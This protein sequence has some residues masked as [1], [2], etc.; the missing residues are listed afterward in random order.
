MY[1]H[2]GNGETVNSAEIVIIL[3]LDAAMTG[4]E[5]TELLKRLEKEKKIFDKTVDG[6]PKSLLL[7]VNK[8]GEKAYL[9]SLAASTLLKRLKPQKIQNII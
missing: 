6:L 3:N 5:N 7:C 8:S 9:S 4:K 2:I 1:L